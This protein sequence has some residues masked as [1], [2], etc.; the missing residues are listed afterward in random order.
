METTVHSNF[1]EGILSS[2]K[3][4]GYHY[5]AVVRCENG[6]YIIVGQSYDVEGHIVG[7]LNVYGERLPLV[8]FEKGK[9]KEFPER[10]IVSASQATEE[11]LSLAA[12]SGLYTGD[13]SI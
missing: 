1:E 6:E 8:S 3:I 9:Y 2:L 4:M 13:L 12:V 5:S 7:E 11:L 10:G